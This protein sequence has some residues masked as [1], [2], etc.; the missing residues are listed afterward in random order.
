MRAESRLAIILEGV[1][2]RLVE[3]L[4]DAAE[5]AERRD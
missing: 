5:A 1:C 4:A 2:A 3:R